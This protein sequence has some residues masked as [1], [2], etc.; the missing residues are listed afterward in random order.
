MAC[1]ITAGFTLGCRDN[2]GGV[3]NIYILGSGSSGSP[4]VTS[5]TGYQDGYITGIAG[6]GTFYKYELAKQTGDYT[7]TINASTENGTVFYEQVINAPFHKMQSSTRNQIKILA[8]NPALKIVVETN[9]GQDDGIGT[10][11]LV[12]Q[13]NGATLSGGTGQTGTG[14]GDLNGY[15]L[16]FTGQEP[17]PASEISGS[18]LSAILTGIDV[19]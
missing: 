12:G 17:L 15:S 10:L 7:E 1:D 2:S 14:F 6:T 18:D 11:F 4:E 5:V 9:N 19:G 3:K 13:Q 8:Q 16:T